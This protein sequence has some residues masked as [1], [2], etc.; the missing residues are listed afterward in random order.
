[1]SQQN[2]PVVVLPP[3][4]QITRNWVERVLVG[5]KFCAPSNPS[6]IQDRVHYRVMDDDL[7]DAMTSL[8]EECEHL[9]QNSHIE[10]TLMIFPDNMQHFYSFKL[11]ADMARELMAEQ[12]FSDQY[13]LELLHPHYR[14]RDSSAKNPIN[15]IK[16]SPYPTLHLVRK[17]CL[18]YA[19]LNFPEGSEDGG[20]KNRMLKRG[21]Q[22]IAQMQ[23]LAGEA[24]EAA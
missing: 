11:V 14:F 6:L 3:A 21:E 5:L 20:K 18:E 9:D 13:Q 10:N 7:D 15:Y 12:G 2:D 8:I 1:M 22:G 4:T 19:L 24:W 17:S 23:C 16:R